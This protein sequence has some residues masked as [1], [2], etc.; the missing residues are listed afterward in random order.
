MLLIHQES[1]V[2]Y[3]IYKANP[4]ACIPKL[5]EYSKCYIIRLLIL[6]N[7]TIKIRI[8]LFYHYFVMQFYPQQISNDT[9]LPAPIL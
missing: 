8:R 7:S 2:I 6:I 3:D 4:I 5:T 9:F 1:L